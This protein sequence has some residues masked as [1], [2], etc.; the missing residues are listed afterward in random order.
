VRA[1]VP[2][3]YRRARSDAPYPF[4]PDNP[5]FTERLFGQRLRLLT[6]ERLWVIPTLCKYCI[7]TDAG[8]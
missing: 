4:G 1:V 2:A 7:L 5:A 3:V 6:V 8:A